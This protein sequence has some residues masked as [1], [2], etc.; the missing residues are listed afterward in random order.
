MIIVESVTA[1]LK[2]AGLVWQTGRNPL[3]VIVECL[4][5]RYGSSIVIHQDSAT[6]NR[7]L[8]PLNVGLLYL[9]TL[10]A[11]RKAL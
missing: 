11:T 8:S 2:G 1:T 4:L 5:I 9:M 7:F 6:T 3:L 10:Q